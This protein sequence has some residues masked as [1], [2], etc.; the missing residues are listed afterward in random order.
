MFQHLNPIKQHS[1]QTGMNSTRLSR[2]WPE[3]KHLASCSRK[4]PPASELSLTKR[5]QNSPRSFVLSSL[6]HHPGSC[7]HR[8]LESRNPR[9]LIA[10]RPRTAPGFAP[11]TPFPQNTASISHFNNFSGLFTCIHVCETSTICSDCRGVS[12]SQAKHS[13]VLWFY[14]VRKMM[15]VPMSV[16]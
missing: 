2:G 16:D 5:L 9:E 7:L 15:P 10:R 1:L 4:E 6:N 11:D 13:M 12:P 3:S 14:F 8:T